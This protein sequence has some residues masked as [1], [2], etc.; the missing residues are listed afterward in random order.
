MTALWMIEDLEWWPDTPEVGQMCE[1]TTYWATPEMMDMPEVLMC[2][3]AARVEESEFDGRV[4]AIAH[5]GQGFTTMLPR[6][7][8]LTGAVTL[9]GWLVWDRYLWTD[10]RTKPT[11]RVLVTERIPVIQRVVAPATER[12]GWYTVAYEGPKTLH[13][14]STIPND[15]R[16]VAY[17]LSVTL[18]EAGPPTGEG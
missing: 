9:T 4:E 5:L 2:T 3:I 8:A 11:G 10:Y 6:D 17:A 7:L 13:R 15:H 18:Q 16:I 12:S 14:S 1:P